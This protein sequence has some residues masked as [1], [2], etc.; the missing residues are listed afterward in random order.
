MYAMLTIPTVVDVTITMIHAVAVTHA[1][2][3]T[4]GDLEMAMTAVL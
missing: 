4:H 1:A 2:A 3:A